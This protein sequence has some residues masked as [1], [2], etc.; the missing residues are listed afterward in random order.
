MY[1]SQALSS[2][3]QEKKFNITL[4][5]SWRNSLQNNYRNNHNMLKTVG[6]FGTASRF[7]QMQGSIALKKKNITNENNIFS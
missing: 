1:N 7:S 4:E 2:Q 6:S 5:P 3:N